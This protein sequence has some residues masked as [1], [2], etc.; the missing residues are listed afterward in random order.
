MATTQTVNEKHKLKLNCRTNAAEYLIV[1][2]SQTI[3]TY[4]WTLPNASRPVHLRRL[5]IA[6]FLDVR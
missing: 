4:K 3:N 6:F 2:L 1:I 5:D